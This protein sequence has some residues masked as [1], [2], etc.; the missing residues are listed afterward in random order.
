[1][2]YD[3]IMSLMRLFPIDY[4]NRFDE[5]IIDEKTNIYSY[6]GGCES[7]EDVEACLIL[8]LCRPIGKGLDKNDANRLLE[9]VNGYFCVEL[10]REDMLSIYTHLC[11]ADYVKQVKKFIEDGFPIDRIK[12]YRKESVV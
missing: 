1:M 4:L 3:Q 2:N 10:T 11:Y 12:Q 8:S 5:L 7:I 6:I 9:R